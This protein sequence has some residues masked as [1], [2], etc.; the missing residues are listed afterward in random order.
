[1][2]ILIW[3]NREA[4]LSLPHKTSGSSPA[5]LFAHDTYSVLNHRFLVPDVRLAKDKAAEV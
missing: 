5:D 2:S 3:I 1:M 4:V